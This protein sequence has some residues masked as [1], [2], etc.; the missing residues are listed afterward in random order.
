MILAFIN[1]TTGINAINIY[2]TT[3]YQNIQDESGGD[4]GISPRLGSVLNGVAQVF[5]AVT[6]PF[7]AYFSFRT[8]FNGGLLIMGIVMSVVAVLEIEGKNTLL[9]C[10]M[11]I[12]LTVYQWTLGTYSWTYLPSVACDEGLSL[13]TATLWGTVFII[14]L[15][16][17]SM[18][19]GL[20]SAGT[21]FLFAGC[22]LVASVFFFFFLKE[23]KGKSRDECQRLYA[24][25]K[26]GVGRKTLDGNIGASQANS[27]VESHSL[28]YGKHSQKR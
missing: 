5:G 27:S 9:I 3:I 17:N 12:F 21:F 8:I 26:D 2:S 10:F 16:T 4:G 11:M 18:F 15:T 20:G 13:G 24:K 22:T 7:I 14:S 19:D 25:N 6:S 28:L 1:Q 23:T